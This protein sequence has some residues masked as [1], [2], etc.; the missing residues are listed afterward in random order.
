MPKYII[1]HVCRHTTI[2]DHISEPCLHNWEFANMFPKVQQVV[3]LFNYGCCSKV[4]CKAVSTIRS[5][6]EA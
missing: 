5:A 1:F 6:H 3:P 4:E 2:V